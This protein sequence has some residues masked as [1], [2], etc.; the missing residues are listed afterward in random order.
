MNNKRIF[1]IVIIHLDLV[2]AGVSYINDKS[3]QAVCD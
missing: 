3:V 1:K 2:Q